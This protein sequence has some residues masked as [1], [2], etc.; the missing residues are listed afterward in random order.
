[1]RRRDAVIRTVMAVAVVLAAA[2]LVGQALIRYIT[3][4]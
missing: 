3:L 1:M 4:D 2:W